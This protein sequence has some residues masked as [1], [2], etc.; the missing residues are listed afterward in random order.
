MLLLIDAFL[1]V[2]SV[3]LFVA[4]HFYLCVYC[5]IMKGCGV[6]SKTLIFGDSS[7]EIV[8]GYSCA[9]FVYSQALALHLRQSRRS[10]LLYYR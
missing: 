3:V 2:E 5:S 1:T 8:F 10:Q 4:C 9:D 7:A 6:L